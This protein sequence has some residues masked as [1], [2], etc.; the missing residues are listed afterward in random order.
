MS[1]DVVVKIEGLLSPYLD[2]YDVDEH[3][4]DDSFTFDIDEHTTKQI[5][6]R[7]MMMMIAT[8]I[9]YSCAIVLI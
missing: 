3:T 9:Y 5:R 6:N 2:E 8:N 7:D 1:K 4:N